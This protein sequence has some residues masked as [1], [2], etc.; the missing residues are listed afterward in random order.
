[1]VTDPRLAAALTSFGEPMIVPQT[2][3]LFDCSEVA[4]GAY[5]IVTGE[6]DVLMLNAQGVPIWSRHVGA[7]GIL[8]LA[9]AIGE[10]VHYVRAI[11]SH[12]TEL[13]FIAAEKLRKLIR[14]NSGIGTSVVQA[15]S[16]EVIDARRKVALFG[17]QSRALNRPSSGE[18]LAG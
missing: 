15:M 2:A 18:S 8:G 1:M 4:D 3:V 6:V 12:H 14:D 11:A 17:S 13:S 16:E 7:G 10:Y 5:V 9:A